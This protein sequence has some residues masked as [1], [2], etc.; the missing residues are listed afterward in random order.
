[1]WKV[2][3]VRDAYWAWEIS[4]VGD[5]KHHGLKSWVWFDENKL[6]VCCVERW[7]LEDVPVWIRE[8]LFKEHKKLA[9]ILCQKYN[10]ER[11]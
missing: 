10:S 8:R 3:A 11:K 5:P 6:P 2:H 7:M 9:E 1:M 4:I